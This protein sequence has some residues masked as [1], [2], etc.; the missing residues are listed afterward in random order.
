MTRIA[1]GAR[2]ATLSV[3]VVSGL[4]ATEWAFQPQQGALS[5]WR[6]RRHRGPG[7]G[8][9]TVATA[10]QVAGDL[11]DI[12]RERRGSETRTIQLRWRCERDAGDYVGWRSEQQAQEPSTG[13]TARYPASERWL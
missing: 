13:S 11:W 7:G 9:R 4:T 5:P 8:C 10:R 2:P 3:A 12:D 6:K 1:E